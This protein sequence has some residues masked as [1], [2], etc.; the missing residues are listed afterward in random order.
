MLGRKHFSFTAQKTKKSMH[1][2]LYM[3]LQASIIIHMFACMKPCGK[4][5]CH[6][7]LEMNCVYI[8]FLWFYCTAPHWMKGF[9]SLEHLSR[10][11]GKPTICICENKDADQ[12]RGNREDDQ[13]LCF[14]Y[15]ESTIPLLLKSEISSF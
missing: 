13:R 12:L 4:F 15:S 7:C 6:L 1:L 2:V 10:P 5:A 14:R 9:G 3:Y 11:M 8:G